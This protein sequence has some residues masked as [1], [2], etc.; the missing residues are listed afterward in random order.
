MYGL[1]VH[2]KLRGRRTGHSA[3]L[4]VV[5]LK[6]VVFVLEDTVLASQSLHL[7]YC[8]ACPELLHTALEV[9]SGK[10]LLLD[11]SDVSGSLL[12]GRCAC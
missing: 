10:R 8:C 6:H 9:Q 2:P 3:W 4:R 1:Y 12:L 7:K 5:S 11:T